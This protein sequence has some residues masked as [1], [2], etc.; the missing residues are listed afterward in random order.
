M[1]TAANAAEPFGVPIGGG[2]VTLTFADLQ[3]RLPNGAD[4][5]GAIATASTSDGIAPRA[6]QLPRPRA[7][8]YEEELLWVAPAPHNSCTAEGGRTRWT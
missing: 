5:V 8:V 1:S 6:Q 2:V 7:S 4:L 3:A